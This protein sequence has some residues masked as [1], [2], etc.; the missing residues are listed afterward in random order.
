MM[1]T[2]KGVKMRRLTQMV[3]AA[4]MFAAMLWPVQATAA[5]HSQ[6]GGFYSRSASC[7]FTPVGPS[8]YVTG[9]G[10]GWVVVQV[11]DPTGT[12]HLFSCFGTT[13][14]NAAFGPAPTN[15]DSVGPPPGVGPLL[16]TVASSGSGYYSCQSHT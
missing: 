16:C 9:S 13:D 7:M 1:A 11:S 5:L 6:C 4:G 2:T 3:L 10:S 8:L 12:V 15:T 14:C